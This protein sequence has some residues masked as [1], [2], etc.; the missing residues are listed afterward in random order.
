M[1]TSGHNRWRYCCAALLA[2]FLLPMA[3]AALPALEKVI[4]HQ[5]PESR[6]ELQS[7]T[8]DLFNEYQQQHNIVSLIF[9]S[10]GMLKLAERFA[11]ENNI[12]KAAE[13]ARTGF[14]YL[15]EAVEGNENDPRVRYLRARV[16]AFLPADL[17][18]CGI[19]LSDT[20]FILA[21]SEKFSDDIRSTVEYMRYRAL[22]HCK[23]H[24]QATDLLAQLKQRNPQLALLAL[25]MNA[26]PEWHSRELTQ[27]VL[28]LSEGR[29]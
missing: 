27:I 17:G 6:A 9:Y 21:A 25:P 26:A 4:Q 22:Y 8:D 24:Q 11:A 2:V 15:D 29:K 28:P 12:I 19:A 7:I 18:R 14:F 23:M 10:Y 3:D 1:I 13:Y 20:Q 16:D 5:L